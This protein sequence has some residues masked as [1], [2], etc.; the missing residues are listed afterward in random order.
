MNDDFKRIEEELDHEIDSFNDLERAKPSRKK[1]GNTPFYAERY[2]IYSWIEKF[3]I[4]A[5]VLGRVC[6][7]STQ[8]TAQ[9]VRDDLLPIAQ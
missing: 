9:R 5:C 4:D 2:G 7:L 6:R 3:V 8:A 1:K